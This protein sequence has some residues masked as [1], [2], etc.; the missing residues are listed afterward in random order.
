MPNE[1]VNVTGSWGQGF[2]QNSHKKDYSAVFF[3]Y[4]CMSP[5]LDYKLKLWNAEHALLW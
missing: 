1:C 4:R 5:S 3:T 2:L